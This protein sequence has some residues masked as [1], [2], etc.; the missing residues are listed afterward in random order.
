MS[1]DDP[2]FARPRPA[3]AAFVL[4]CADPRVLARF[5]AELLDWPIIHEDDVWSHLRAPEGPTL[6]FQRVDGHV[7]PVWPGAEHPQ[8]AHVDLEVDDV[9]VAAAALE[10][11]GLV[12]HPVQPGSTFVVFTD[13]AGHPFCLVER[14]SYRD[15]PIGD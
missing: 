4:D 7:P 13:P 12:R 2:A 3:L 1:P 15:G 10:A 6:A 9:H 14:D 8:Q 5:Y 11:R